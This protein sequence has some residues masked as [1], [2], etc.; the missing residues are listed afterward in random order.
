MCRPR[1]ARCTFA[2]TAV[3]S[4]STA[5]G[6]GLDSFE[7]LGKMVGPAVSRLYECHCGLTG[8][9]PTSRR[10]ALQRPRRSICAEYFRAGRTCLFRRWLD[11]RI[12]IVPQD[13]ATMYQTH[14]KRA[15]HAAA[16]LRRAKNGSRSRHQRSG[17]LVQGDRIHGCCR[18]IET[19]VSPRKS[20]AV[21]VRSLRP[22]SLRLQGASTIQQVRAWPWP[23]R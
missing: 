18:L 19:E 8:L 20:T 15:R 13:E 16:T 2:V 22:A 5:G 21:Q 9:R 10:G 3:L 1:V 4:S 7:L 6:G 14:T 12:R 17:S 23:T 11:S